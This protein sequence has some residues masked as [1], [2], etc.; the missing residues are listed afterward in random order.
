MNKPTKEKK[1]QIIKYIHLIQ[2]RQKKKRK[3]GTKNRGDK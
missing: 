3:E 2:R 1:N